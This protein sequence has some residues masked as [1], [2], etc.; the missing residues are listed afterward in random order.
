MTADLT[1]SLMYPSKYVKA[2]DLIDKE[3]KARAVT[4]TIESVG[5]S[6]LKMA[7]G[8][9]KRSTVIHLKDKE[10][11]FVACKTNGYALGVLIS[12][13]SK[14]WV[15]KRMVL[16]P[17]MDTLG[18]KIVPCIRIQGSPDATPERAAA[19]ARAWK[20]ERKGGKLISRL[21]DALNSL[22]PVVAQPVE[23]GEEEEQPEHNEA[24][25]SMSEDD[26][27]KEG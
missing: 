2:E 5:V 9:D 24:P 18:R 16:I 23:K 6:N 11:E 10:K 21:K 3:G 8:K 22:G 19:Y 7:Q 27:G 20:G 25:A 15:G 26:F 12:A 13:N 17:D 1:L 14:D 4:V